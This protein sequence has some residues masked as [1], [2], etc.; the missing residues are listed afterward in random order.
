MHRFWGDVEDAARLLECCQKNEGLVYAMFETSCFHD[1]LY[2]MEKLYAADVF[3]RVVY[4]EGE[5][6]HPR[7]LGA[8]S[9]GSYK[10]WRKKGCPMWYPTHSTAYYV[11]VS[12]GQFTSV[13]C[14]GFKAPFPINR[15]GANKYNNEFTDEIALYQTTEGGASRQ[16]MCKSVVGYH[17][18]AGRVFGEKGSMVG[19]KY[20]GRA[21][22]KELGD[23]TRPILPPGVSGGGHGGS[24]GLE[25]AAP[26]AAALRASGV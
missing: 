17:A 24:R 21:T 6:C 26:R 25:M 4:S 5:Y 2:A 18:E 7:S 8:P 1:D 22:P 19:T 15:P 20:T 3:G 14:G 12:G 10:D 23:V 9:I 13:S 16:C 11:G